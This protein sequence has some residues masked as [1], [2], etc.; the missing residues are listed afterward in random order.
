M[1]PHMAT[2]PPTLSDG[3]GSFEVLAADVVEVHVDAALPRC[4]LQLLHAPGRR[5]S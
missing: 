3:Q 5:C 1:A 4:S 2:R